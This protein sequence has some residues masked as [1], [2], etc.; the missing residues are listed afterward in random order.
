MIALL[1]HQQK[2]IQHARRA[3]D[4]RAS[5]ILLFHIM[6]SGKTVT[7]LAICQELF[8][9]RKVTVY[10]PTHI[11]DTWNIERS[12]FFPDADVTVFSHDALLTMTADPNRIVIVDE[13]HHLFDIVKKDHTVYTKLR[14]FHRAYLLTGTPFRKG[15]DEISLYVN[16]VSKKNLIPRSFSEYESLYMKKLTTYQRFWNGWVMAAWKFGSKLYVFSTMRKFPFF[17]I[18]FHVFASITE[19]ILTHVPKPDIPKLV[20]AIQSYVSVVVEKDIVHKTLRFPSVVRTNE[21]FKYTTEQTN[22]IIGILK[23][24]GGTVSEKNLDNLYGTDANAEYR[25]AMANVMSNKIATRGARRQYG[26]DIGRVSGF[27]SSK[28]A[29]PQKFKYIVDMCKTR[30]RVVI[31]S[32][33]GHVARRIAE[34]LGS[35]GL[36]ARLYN[37]VAMYPKI[38]VRK[39]QQHFMADK[40]IIILHPKMT[41]GISI[42][43]AS[44]LIITEPMTDAAKKQQ[45]EARVVRIGSHQGVKTK[46]VEIVTCVTGFVLDAVESDSRDITLAD[47]GPA[48]VHDVEAQVKIGWSLTKWKDVLVRPP[49]VIYDDIGHLIPGPEVS[50][51]ISMRKLEGELNGLKSGMAFPLHTLQMMKK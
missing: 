19:Q 12:S 18:F 15:L 44:T 16:I 35:R 37:A 11:R 47:I 20:A 2:T 43:G 10:C 50:Q 36:S 32:S 40:D 21:P 1:E 29:A 45:I 49:W 34:Y 42:K 9:D 28:G 8:P 7:A 46:S 13:A 22:K 5:G 38:D 17:S 23:L 27:W 33:F 25:N 30:K 48:V 26:E 41:E 6:G 3:N 39:M 14:K 4:T 51:F 31:Y 24:Q